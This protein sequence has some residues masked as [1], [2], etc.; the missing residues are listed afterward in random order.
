MHFE[1]AFGVKARTVA[2]AQQVPVVFR[3][4]AGATVL[5]DTWAAGERCGRAKFSIRR[6]D[7]AP[8]SSG[9]FE[10]ALEREGLQSRWSCTLIVL[11]LPTARCWTRTGS[12][13][14]R[15]SWRTAEWPRP[16][17][18]ARVASGGDWSS[19]QGTSGAFSLLRCRDAPWWKPRRV[20]VLALFHDRFDNRSAVRQKGV[21]CRSSIR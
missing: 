20:A 12:G 8:R 7:C 3:G 11:I 5:P 9:R 10:G 18:W 21:A 17:A 16:T 6:F 4:A 15:S 1:T 2:F 19:T 13:F 14:P